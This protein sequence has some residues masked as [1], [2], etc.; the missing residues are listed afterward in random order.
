MSRIQ[1]IL[2][3]LQFPDRYETL[4]SYA[5]INIANIL[6]PPTKKIM[7]DFEFLT[8]EIKSRR[9]GVL[10][11][12]TGE[13]GIGKTTFASNLTQWIPNEFSSTLQYSKA[14]SYENLSTSYNEAIY[15]LPENDNRIIP[16]NIDHREGNPPSDQEIAEIK[17]FLRTTNKK[18]ALLIWPETNESNANL[19][20]KK[21]SQIAGALGIDVP[22]KVYGPD[23]DLWQ[24]IASST[25]QL[26]NGVNNLE[27]LGV[28]PKNYDT[29]KYRTLGQ[30]LREIQQD[31]NREKFKLKKSTQKPINVII[32]FPSESTDPGIL[33]SLYNNARY[34]LLDAAA[35]I[36]STPNSAIGKWWNDRRNILIRAIV[37]MNVNAFC[38]PP[39]ASIS[40]LRNASDTNGAKALDDLGIR[41]YGLARAA[42]DLGRSDFGRFLLTGTLAGSEGRGTPATD[43]VAAF[44]HIA[45]EGFNLGKDKELNKIMSNAI[46]SL[47]KEN[48]SEFEEIRYEKKLDFCPLIPDNSIYRY[49]EVVCIEYTWRQGEFLDSGNKSNVAQYILNKLKNYVIELG[50]VSR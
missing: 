33:T 17:R 8:M 11:P 49:N 37:Q 35:L 10:V 25:M 2:D 34:G 47:L 39:A 19:I 42:R 38:M 46:E 41:R 28:D 13:S 40:C 18:P 20:S 32:A 12:I 9:E 21:Y 3:Q 44:K 23:R 27:L 24:Q 30:F 15:N 50:W 6:I 48:N 7:D 45:K 26:V 29:K 22:A 14:I 16:I 36:N 4:E 1:H 31:F 43:A 5:G